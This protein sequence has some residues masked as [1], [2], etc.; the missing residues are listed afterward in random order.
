MSERV[1]NRKKV[2][3]EL[4][5]TGIWVYEYDRRYPYKYDITE[6]RYVLG[7][8]FDT[9]ISKALICI[10]INP[11]T[12]IPEDLDPT[13]LRIQKYAQEV[14]QGG[15]NLYGAWYM[16]NVYPQRSTDPNGMDVDGK[17]RLDIH[18]RNLDEIQALLK[19][20]KGGA[21]VWCAWGNN[22][23]A[24]KRGFLRE[25]LYEI[26]NLFK[27][28]D[29]NAKNDEAHFVLKSHVVTEA[30]HP[31]HP[32]ASITDPNKNEP[33]DEVSDASEQTTRKPK[34]KVLDK[35]KSFNEHREK[36]AKSEFYVDY[37]WTT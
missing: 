1:K 22:I 13:L 2:M 31:A 5:K 28:A 8:I 18:K 16:L 36:L 24:S 20:L 27:E 23:D 12:A 3:K 30:G 33:E 10:G 21:D 6:V 11:S 7:E 29:K 19:S 17:E 32:L 37:I 4:K 14:K 25:Y 15:N 26:L 35:L 34:K 9:S